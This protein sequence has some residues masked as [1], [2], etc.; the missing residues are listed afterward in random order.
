MM[1]YKKSILRISLV[2]K[3]KHK[4]HISLLHLLTADFVKGE[5][6]TSC[7]LIQPPGATL[8]SLLF[9]PFFFSFP[10]RREN[11]C[12]DVKCSIVLIAPFSGSRLMPS[13]QRAKLDFCLHPVSLLTSLCG[14]EKPQFPAHLPSPASLGLWAKFSQPREQRPA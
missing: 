11:Y 8:Q 2:F 12:P 3:S 14:D 13:P 7:P 4:I 10:L 6:E 9:F 5:K 1:M